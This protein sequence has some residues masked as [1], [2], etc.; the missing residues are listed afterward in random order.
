MLFF[1]K[2]WLRIFNPFSLGFGF[3]GREGLGLGFSVKSLGLRR[4]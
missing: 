4:V 1:L 2:N 3:R